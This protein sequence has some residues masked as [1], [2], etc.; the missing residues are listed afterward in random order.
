MAVSLSWTPFTCRLGVAHGQPFGATDRTGLLE[1]KS[2]SS[3]ACTTTRTIKRPSTPTPVA[4][5]PAQ[6]L[7]HYP[8]AEL[9]L[10]GWTVP[11]APPPTKAVASD[12]IPTRHS[13]QAL[14]ASVEAFMLC[15]GIPAGFQSFSSLVDRYQRTSQLRLPSHPIGVLLWPDGPRLIATRSNS[16]T[17]TSPSSIPPSAATGLVVYGQHRG[18]PV[19]NRAA[20]LERAMPHVRTL[21]ATAEDLSKKPTGKSNRTSDTRRTRHDIHACFDSFRSS[22]PTLPP[23]AFTSWPF[24]VTMLSLKSTTS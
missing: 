9:S 21:Y 11:S 24:P 17:T 1:A 20:P 16:S 6:I 14:T 10:A 7:R 3:R 13:E 23:L 8:S 19:K 2:I 22:H 4:A 15:N 18:Y 12:P 5:L